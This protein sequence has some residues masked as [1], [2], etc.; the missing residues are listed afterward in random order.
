VL[1]HDKIS[2]WHDRRR[3]GWVYERH[4]RWFKNARGK[5]QSLGRIIE[6]HR[7]P[8]AKGMYRRTETTNERA[9][10]VENTHGIGTRVRIAATN[11]DPTSRHAQ[12]QV[13]RREVSPNLE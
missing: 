12:C 5:V 9:V 13:T 6:P 2:Q 10:G 11:I 8:R 3:S 1:A 7:S 4:L